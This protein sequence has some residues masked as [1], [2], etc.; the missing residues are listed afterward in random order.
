MALPFEQL[1]IGKETPAN[2]QLHTIWQLEPPAQLT[3]PNWNL[4]HY[5]KRQLFLLCLSK[6]GKSL[7]N[8][9]RSF[10]AMFIH[11]NQGIGLVRSL[12]CWTGVAQNRCPGTMSPGRTVGQIVLRFGSLLLLK[13]CMELGCL[14]ITFV[15][16]VFVGNNIQDTD[17]IA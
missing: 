2:I 15:I 5:T 7:T 10:A 11:F 1:S 9:S 13:L 14:V 4:Q 6:H 12:F 8:D 17:L 3:L 16:L